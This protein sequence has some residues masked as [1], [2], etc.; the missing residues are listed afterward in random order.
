MEELHVPMMYLS[1]TIEYILFCLLTLFKNPREKIL[2]MLFF[3][4]LA[5]DN[6]SI[7]NRFLLF[8]LHHKN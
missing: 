2:K 6:I 7:R 8:L 4:C 1:N 3:S 5:N